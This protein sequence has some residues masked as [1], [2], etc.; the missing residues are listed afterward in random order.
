MQARELAQGLRVLAF[1]PGT[2]VFSSQHPCR[3]AHNLLQF[4]LQGIC[5]PL[6]ASP[7]ICTYTQKYFLIIKK[8][9]ERVT[10]C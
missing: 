6:L 10:L 2:H 1:P 3:A 4:Q 7:G 9:K 8:T 5:C